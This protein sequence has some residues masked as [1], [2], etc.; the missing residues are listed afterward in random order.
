MAKVINYRAR[1]R[2][3]HELCERIDD[4]AFAVNI[5]TDEAFRSAAAQQ[6]TRCVC[7]LENA[8]IDLSRRHRGKHLPD[9]LPELLRPQAH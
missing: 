3:L 9:D 4:W 8:A 1:V 6:L 2:R 5:A 7:A